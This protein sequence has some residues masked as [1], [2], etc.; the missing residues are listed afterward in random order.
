MPPAPT[1]E[2]WRKE[3]LRIWDSM[4][5]S[6]KSSFRRPP[7]GTPLTE[8]KAHL[9]DK[10]SRGVDG[11]SD[12]S[13]QENFVVMV[14]FVNSADLL[15]DRLCKRFQYQRVEGTEWIEQEVCP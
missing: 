6:M 11:S 4:Q 9:I 7:P 3:Y 2:E 5:G 8:E 15:L 14:M 13:G 1:P 12:E 10:I